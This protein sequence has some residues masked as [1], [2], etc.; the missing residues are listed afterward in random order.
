MHHGSWK[1][2]I[3]IT[4]M[5]G[6]TYTVSFLNQLLAISGTLDGNAFLTVLATGG[7]RPKDNILST[8]RYQLGLVY[9]GQPLQWHVL[10]DKQEPESPPQFLF[11]TSPSFLQD[12]DLD[13][14]EALVPSLVNWNCD[15]DRALVK[16]VNEM[17]IVFRRMQV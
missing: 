16:V 12:L 15:D 5:Y 8:E 7:H 11:L 3:L 10:F 2:Y 4:Y 17:L 1:Y 6:C 14:L 13:N 9:A